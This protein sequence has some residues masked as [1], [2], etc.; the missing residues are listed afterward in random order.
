MELASYLACATAPSGCFVAVTGLIRPISAFWLNLSTAL[1][2]LERDFCAAGSIFLVTSS[3]VRCTLLLSGF[4]GLM[5]AGLGQCLS[6]LN[7]RFPASLTPGQQ[8]VTWSPAMAD[9]TLVVSPSLKHA[10]LL[11]GF[12]VVQGFE[13]WAPSQVSGTASASVPTGVGVEGGEVF[14][15]VTGYT[16]HRPVTQVTWLEGPAETQPIRIASVSEGD[17]IQV[18]A[19]PNAA[20]GAAVGGLGGPLGAWRYL[21]G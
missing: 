13:Q 7:V 8:P 2:T 10:G 11:R 17:P 6:W 12:S 1:S 5:L 4:N 9:G 16:P 19:R 21:W 14:Q 20:S 15:V 18:N 3:S